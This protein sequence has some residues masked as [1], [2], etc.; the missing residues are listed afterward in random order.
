MPV[1][2]I[3]LRL[4]PSDPNFLKLLDYPLGFFEK[5]A[6]MQKIQMQFELIAESILVFFKTYSD[7]EKLLQFLGE[8]PL[9]RNPNYVPSEE[10]IRWDIVLIKSTSERRDSLLKMFAEKVNAFLGPLGRVE[11]KEDRVNLNLPNNFYLDKYFK[12][13]DFSQK[14]RNR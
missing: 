6:Q 9:E 7:F 1:V 5:F 14:S 12:S 3:I 4:I 8:F 11:L 13:R 10:F 2:E